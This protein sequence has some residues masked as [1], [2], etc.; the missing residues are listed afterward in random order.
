LGFTRYQGFDPSP[1][2][3]IHVK[4]GGDITAS[5]TGDEFFKLTT[6]DETGYSMAYPDTLNS[7]VVNGWNCDQSY[8]CHGELSRA[9]N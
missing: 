1:Y 8:G 5:Q 4:I 6:D 9:T 7:W 2:E 3:K